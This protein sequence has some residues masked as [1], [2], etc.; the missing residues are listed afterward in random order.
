VPQQRVCNLDA[1]ITRVPLASLLVRTL[2]L[3]YE[4]LLLSAVLWCAGLIF[5]L[6]ERTAGWPHARLL[7]QVYLVI[8]SGMYF[9]VQWPQVQ[10]LPMKTWR[11]KLVTRSGSKIGFAQAFARYIVATAGWALLGC[12]YWWALF[13]REHQFLHDRVA[14]TRL[15]RYH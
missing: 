9:V 12:A 13:D 6:A 2:S 7:F 5:A 8:V 15:V 14:G 3:I 10:T 11:M 1:D 4:A